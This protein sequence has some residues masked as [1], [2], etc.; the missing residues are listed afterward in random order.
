[1][2]SLY[3]TQFFIRSNFFPV[4][5]RIQSR[6]ISMLCLFVFHFFIRQNPSHPLVGSGGSPSRRWVAPPPSR[7][8]TGRSWGPIPS[9]WRCFPAV[10]RIPRPLGNESCADIEDRL[11][12]TVH[13]I[14]KMLG[15]HSTHFSI[16]MFELCPRGINRHYCH[17]ADQ[18]RS[19]V[20]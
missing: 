20:M 13:F 19:V 10:C 18:A 4:Q 9:R 14:E 7:W 6:R 16:S 11:S 1:M 3:S 15:Q 8:W 2:H 12:G 5:W 17:V